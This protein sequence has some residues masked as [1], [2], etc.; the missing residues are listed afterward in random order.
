MKTALVTG[1]S[2]GI[3]KQIGL[4]LL[5]LN[6]N[7]YFNGRNADKLKECE[8]VFNINAKY[9]LLSD[10]S[11]YQNIKKIA[12]DFIANSI[13]LDV[14][15]LNIGTTDRSAFGNITYENWKNVI[16]INL[17]LPFFLVQ[18]LR[19]NIRKNGKII[20]ISSILGIIPD[21]SSISYGVSKAGIN[22]LVPYLAKDFTNQGITVNAIAPGFIDTEW[23]LNKPNDQINRI[24][25]KTLANRLGTV[26]EVSKT[27]QFIINTDYI[28]GQ[29]IRCDGGYGLK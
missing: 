16:D 13:C 7:V 23:H 26:N 28:N 10:L 2:S 6:Y 19:N 24:A 11:K 8:N 17:N 5:N 29:I 21:G 18:S 1:S 25:N 12:S 27:V 9:C 14:L 20:F 22:M 15:V 4:D 3:G